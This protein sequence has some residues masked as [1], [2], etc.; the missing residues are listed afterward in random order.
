MK[1]STFYLFGVDRD[2]F[3]P[4]LTTLAKK[5]IACVKQLK[6]DLAVLRDRSSP[7]DMPALAHR[8]LQAEKA[9]E[10]WEDILHEGEE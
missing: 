3:E 10:H 6:K 7:G 9:Q 8:Y 5:K 2:H 1:H 4:E